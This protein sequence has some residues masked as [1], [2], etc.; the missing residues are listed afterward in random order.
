MSEMARIAD[1]LRRSQEG[2]A[3]H[4]PALGEL[5][6]D[7]DA[8]LA[9]R[10]AGPAAH[11]IWELLLHVTAW[12]AATTGALQGRA[13]PNMTDAEDWPSTGH[14]EP[15]WREA[16]ASEARVNQELAAAVERFPEQRLGDQVPGRD[17]S[18]YFLLHGI[19]QHNLYHAGQVALL[20]K[21]AKAG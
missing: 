16:V 14:S 8:Q 20:K 2:E 9:L 19:T 17:Y 21:L 15:E 11:N 10:R 3:S 1:Q 12:Q 6:T 7:V 13:M 5:L 4:G 18:F